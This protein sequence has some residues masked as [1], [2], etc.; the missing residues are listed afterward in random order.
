[1]AAVV[2]LAT[3]VAQASM[4]DMW[5]ALSKALDVSASVAAVQVKERKQEKTTPLGAWVKGGAAKT[6]RA[7]TTNGQCK[8]CTSSHPTCD[9]CMHVAQR[10]PLPFGCCLVGIVLHSCA[11]TSDHQHD[12]LLPADLHPDPHCAR[13]ALVVPQHQLVRAAPGVGVLVCLFVLC[14]LCAYLCCVGKCLPRCR[15]FSCEWW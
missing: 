4:R 3:V 8:S 9:H 2:P 7:P 15:W 5:E 13:A 10:L 12:V 14:V 1:M 11:P 6:T